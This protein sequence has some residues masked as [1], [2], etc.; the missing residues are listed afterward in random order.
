MPREVAPKLN[1]FRW[2][3]RPVRSDRLPGSRFCHHRPDDLS[4]SSRQ[5]LGSSHHPTRWHYFAIARWPIHLVLNRPI[6]QVKRASWA[7]G[8]RCPIVLFLESTYPLC[9]LDTV[10]QRH[11]LGRSYLE[12]ALPTAPHDWHART[13]ATI[14]ASG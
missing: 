12:F 5:L 2:C 13:R 1:V 6:D 8:R 4:K 9:L 3:P 7:L 14:P 10:S 11:T